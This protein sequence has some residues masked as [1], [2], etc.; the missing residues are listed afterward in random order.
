MVD[1]KLISIADAARRLTEAGDSISRP[2]LSLYLTQHAEAGLFLEENG[3]RLVDFQRLVAHRAE[4]VR[5]KLRPRQ[6]TTSVSRP[7]AGSFD[8]SQ[9]NGAARKALADAELKD[10]ELAARRGEVT[11][12][13]EVRRTA[14]DAIALMR[15]AFERAVETEAA[16]IGV[17][18]GWDERKLRIVFK[19][20]ARRGIEEF[21]RAVLERLD[22]QARAEAAGD[23]PRSDPGEAG[24]Q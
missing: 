3:R 20:V 18:Y 17:S 13:E 16:R 24:L 1:L 8:R 10:L 6:G 22:A 21:N 15:S 5:L 7:G 12:T 23:G 11:P 4:N 14:H 9:A 2:G 19:G